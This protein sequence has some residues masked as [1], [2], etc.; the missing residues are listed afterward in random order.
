MNRVI[1]TIE[2]KT[3]GELIYREDITLGQMFSFFVP[4]TGYGKE[5]M[6]LVET[7]TESE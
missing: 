6:I 4:K 2:E 5:I 3:T 7:K 1:V